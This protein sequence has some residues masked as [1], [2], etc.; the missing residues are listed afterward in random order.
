M[1]VKQNKGHDDWND[2][3]QESK[4]KNIIIIIIS[5]TISFTQGIYTY[6]PEKKPCM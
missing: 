2:I 4:Y 6:M 5:S 3:Q 1:D